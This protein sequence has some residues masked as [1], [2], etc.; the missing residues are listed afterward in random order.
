MCTYNGAR[1][2][3]EQ[4]ESIAQQTLPPDELV[5]CDDGSTD[6][7]Q[8]IIEDFRTSA[9]FPVRFCQ[10]AVTLGVQSNFDQAIRLCRGDLISLSDQ[11]DVWH[12]DKLQKSAS[13]LEAAPNAGL[14]MADAEIVDENLNPLGYTAWAGM[15]LSR[16]DKRGI[17][18]RRA[19]RM[20]V[21]QNFVMGST[22]LFRSE[23]RDIILPIP[24]DF[25]LNHDGWIALITSAITDLIVLDE[26]VSLYRKHENQKAGAWPAPG[27]AS[28]SAV[29]KGTNYPTR[30]YIG[31][32][33]ELS[34]V[35]DR[36][37]SQPSRY[38]KARRASKYLADAMA[39]Y[40]RRRSLPSD[41]LRRFALVAG[42]IASG[43]YHQYSNGVLS[44]ARDVIRGARP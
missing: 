29:N 10:N 44:A 2:L 36:L 7:T 41:E 25:Y 43:R 31:Q 12:I 1:F 5:I 42:E 19:F 22:A 15:G 9:A 17:N 30:G 18:G 4:L 32:L 3:A 11:D 13:A 34:A 33:D 24:P 20:L 35:R 6:G 40:E 8:S 16:Y 37:G 14:L 21:R 38:P 23:L 28:E 27:A 26:T 39:H